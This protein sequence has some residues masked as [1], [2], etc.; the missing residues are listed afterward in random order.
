[1]NHNLCYRNPFEKER[2][3]CTMPALKEKNYEESRKKGKNPENHP[4]AWLVCNTS[5]SCVWFVSMCT[6]EREGERY[7]HKKQTMSTPIETGT[8]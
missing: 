2:T 3:I 1:M 6:K 4:I 8:W 5:S 7:D